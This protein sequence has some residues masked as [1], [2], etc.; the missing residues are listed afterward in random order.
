[1]HK[2]AAFARRGSLAALLA[3]LLVFAQTDTG[4]GR[5]TRRAIAVRAV[6]A[7]DPT[8]QP[9]SLDAVDN[10]ALTAAAYNGDANPT[11]IDTIATTRGDAYTAIWP[12]TGALATGGEEPVYAITMLGEF[13]NSEWA[14]PSVAPSSFSS[15]TLVVDA[16]TGTLVDAN[17]R[18]ADVDLSSLGALTQLPSAD[19]GVVVGQVVTNGARTAACGKAC[20]RGSQIVV[21]R[22]GRV[23][24]RHE[25]SSNGGFRLILPG[26][27]Y[28]L[29]MRHS[30][31][32]G[33]V[34]V[35]HRRIA[36]VRVVCR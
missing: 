36:R 26:G 19:Q 15:L 23:I 14:A 3:G 10:L 29:R 30:C 28:A 16:A 22:R 33:S 4:H 20:Q 7:D 24:G 32:L 2:I 25:V 35:E 9:M 34:H 21:V 12:N 11:V 8:D 31:S 27:A 6:V 13:N 18:N 1:V 5:V 17:L